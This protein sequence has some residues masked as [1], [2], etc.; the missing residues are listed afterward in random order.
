MLVAGS[1]MLPPWLWLL[2]FVW[3]GGALAIRLLPGWGLGAVEELRRTVL[4][5]IAVYAGMG[6][7]LFVLHRGDQISR[8][9]VSVAFLSCLPLLPYVRIRLKAFLVARGLWGMPCIVFGDVV[10]I[11]NVLKALRGEP[12]LGY[13]PVAVQVLGDEAPSAEIDGVPVV[14]ATALR[15]PG[16]MAAILA[17][18]HPSPH[19]LLDL[20]EGPLAGFRRLLVVPDFI[21]AAAVWGQPRD[22]GGVLGLEISR[23]LQDAWVRAA[24]RGFDLVLVALVL[25]LW[26]VAMP[27]IALLILA[28]DR[29]TPF[30]IHRRVGR[31]GREFPMWKFRTMRTGAEQALPQAIGDN[32][33]LRRQ[34]EVN[35]KL[36]DDPRVTPFGRFLR[37]SSLDEL[38][39][40]LNVVR[41][42]MSI[43]GPRPLPAYH[44]REIPERLRQWRE[45]VRPGVTGLWQVSGRSD[46]GTAGIIRSDAYYLR[47]WSIWLDIV[48]LVRTL[49]VIWYRAGAY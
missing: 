10:S 43:V 20:V 32:E 26:L 22:L 19:Q 12:G 42:E 21:D 30:F 17:V 8:I 4:L 33:E 38:P 39:Q 14:P 31:G 5:L 36:A 7:A 34:W 1:P 23:N 29:Q 18:Q 47:H 27:V 41:G 15:Q 35:F 45:T 37:R 25:P 13:R 9:T 11:G 40:L 6:T 28:R 3:W 2:P 24:K 44:A 48:I 49:R 46:A 16:A